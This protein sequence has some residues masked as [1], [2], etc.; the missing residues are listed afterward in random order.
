MIQHDHPQPQST[1]I[2]VEPAKDSSQLDVDMVE[3]D[4][5][6]NISVEETM[7]QHAIKKLEIR[8]KQEMD[9]LARKMEE[10]K[11]QHAQ[12]KENYRVQLVHTFLS[13]KNQEQVQQQESSQV[14]SDNLR[15]LQSQKEELEKQIDREKQRQNNQNQNNLSRPA[16]SSS[17]QSQDSHTEHMFSPPLHINSQKPV[18]QPVP[19]VAYVNQSCASPM[20]SIPQQQYLNLAPTRIVEVT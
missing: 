12:D 4:H 19:R 16:R 14:Q 6:Q 11:Q 7:I 5:D 3:D 9:S 17:R 8:Q 20:A 13:K 10:I 2:P 15:R 18:V 1:F